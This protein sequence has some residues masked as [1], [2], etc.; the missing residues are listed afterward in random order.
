VIAAASAPKLATS[1]ISSPRQ[2]VVPKVG[3][4][5]AVEDPNAAPNGRF[6]TVVLFDSKSRRV[7]G[8][9]GP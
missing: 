5:W 7:G 3:T 1:A 4:Y 6:L 8:H 2:V 9:T